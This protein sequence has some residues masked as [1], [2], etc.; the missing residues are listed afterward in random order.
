MLYKTRGI[1][2]K[3]T[4]YSESSVVVQIFTEKFGLQSY[5]INGVK[6]PKAKIKQNILQPLYLLDLVVYNKPSANIQRVSEIK[7]AHIFQTVPYD[8][9]KSSIVLFLNEVLYKSVKL[10]S[11]DEQLFEFVFHA[12]ALLDRLDRG[13]SLFH[14]YFL[15]RLTKYLGFYPH[16]AGET[17]PYFDLLEGVFTSSLPRHPFLLR[18]DETSHWRQLLS[19]S[20]E[21]LPLVRLPN[22]EKQL[23]LEHILSYYRL[24]IDGFKDIKS[25][26]I[27][28]DVLS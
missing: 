12:I 18:G 13:V 22:T 3:S 16:V 11:E 24:H 10:Q 23:M 26:Q 14:L 27:L 21:N 9:R 8:I 1:V 25:H 2:F 7:P 19:S 17:H 20:F 4:D 28:V 5:L 15:L 6:R